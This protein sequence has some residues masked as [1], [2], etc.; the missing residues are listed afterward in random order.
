MEHYFFIVKQTDEPDVWVSSQTIS[1]ARFCQSLNWITVIILFFPSKQRQLI[2]K[3]NAVRLKDIL[4]DYF[5]FY[6]Y[7]WVVCKLTYSGGTVCIEQVVQSGG[8]NELV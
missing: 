7:N 5:K 3:F 1:I 4:L 8:E 6:M 2:F